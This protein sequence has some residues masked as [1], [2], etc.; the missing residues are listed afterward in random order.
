LNGNV[1]LAGIGGEKIVHI[2]RTHGAREGL[3]ATRIIVCPEK[4]AEWMMAQPISGYSIH[5]RVAIPHGAGHRW[6]AVYEPN[7]QT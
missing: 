7:Q 2:L 4:D 3:Q 5:E 1:V 6:I